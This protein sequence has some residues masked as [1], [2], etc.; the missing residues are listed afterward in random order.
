MAHEYGS[1][2]D[3]LMNS[4][5][6]SM[7]ETPE[8]IDQQREEKSS[9][10][11]NA[12]DIEHTFSDIYDNNQEEVTDESDSEFV[13]DSDNVQDEYGNEIEP[14]KTY[15][16]DELNERINKAMR[17]R[18]ERMQRNNPDKAEAFEKAAKN[19]EADPDSNESWQEQLETFVEQ[20]LV[21]MSHK[22]VRQQ[23]EAI[24]RQ[25]QEEFE[26]KFHQGKEKFKDFSDIVGKASITDAM[27]MGSRGL[28]DPAAFWYAASKLQATELDRISKISDPYKQS[29]EIGRL[30][31]R[32]RKSKT[33]TA[34]PKPIAH[35]RG[36]MV[37]KTKD[38]P[39]QPSIEDMMHASA[40]KIKSK[41]RQRYKV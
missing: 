17:E 30:D 13:D 26:Q 4:K 33:G 12:Y 31:E 39:R 19:F 22:Q 20:T 2:D 35:V 15:T 41:Q 8:V 11:N 24:E 36:D 37:M 21:K 10:V 1:I 34:A 14:A 32:M 27:V 6:T 23:Q 16:E 38:K 29:A 40:A 5:P 3:A 9:E 18:F 28:K 7:P 25:E